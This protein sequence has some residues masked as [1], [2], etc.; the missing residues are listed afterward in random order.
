MTDIDKLIEILEGTGTTTDT[1]GALRL[2]AAQ[3]L[4]DLR[5]D[6]EKH[7]DHATDC[8]SMLHLSKPRPCDCGLDAARKRWL[9]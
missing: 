4:C 2:R 5:A 6:F 3:A 7:A 9:E 1:T 8:D